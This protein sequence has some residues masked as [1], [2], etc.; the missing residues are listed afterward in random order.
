MRNSYKCSIDN[1]VPCITKNCDHVYTFGKIFHWQL[2]LVED[3]IRFVRGCKWGGNQGVIIFFASWEQNFLSQTFLYRLTVKIH[4]SLMALAFEV[5][6]SLLYFK[7]WGIL[8]KA[9]D[10]GEFGLKNTIL[11]H[12]FCIWTFER[13]FW[14]VY[15]T[16]FG[17]IR[18]ETFHR[19]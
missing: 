7:E 4:R 9:S 11:C 8:G 19:S 3:I 13:Y 17:F 18:E 10:S 5:Y 12:F 16:V 15:L 6:R 14:R 1:S 2:K